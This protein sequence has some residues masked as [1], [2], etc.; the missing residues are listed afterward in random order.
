[1]SPSPSSDEVE[2]SAQAVDQLEEGVGESAI[3]PAPAP[4]AGGAPV[5]RPRGRPKGSKNK[6]T[7][8][9]E[10]A[11]AAA[12]AS[13]DPAAIAA[14][15]Q[16]TSAPKKRG[17]PPKVKTDDGEPAPKKKR[18]RPPKTKPED[19]EEGGDEAAEPEK[20]KRGRPPKSASS[21]V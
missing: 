20:K 19:A 1:M 12:I 3:P 21:A 4:V 16:A 15:E 5:K 9:K 13:G 17:R 8:E 18:G 6:K 14:A 2:E 10:A 11:Q 7:L